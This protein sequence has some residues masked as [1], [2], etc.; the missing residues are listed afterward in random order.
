M[1]RITADSEDSL[2]IPADYVAV[3]MAAGGSSRFHADRHKLLTPIRGKPI[4]LHTIESVQ[5][6]GYG[7]IVVVI[8]AQAEAF[9]EILEKIPVMTVL[10][11]EWQQG[12]STSLQAGIRNLPDM[13]RSACLVLADQPFVS[14]RTY[15]E[16]AQSQQEHANRIIVP[17]FKGKYGNPTMFPA[18]T[19]AELKTQPAEDSGGRR[20]LRKYGAVEVETDDPFVIRDID[21]L[22]D[23]RKYS[24]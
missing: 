2:P 19:F 1:A 15:H 13:I 5:S 16:L 21:T 23:F 17:T 24:E 7:T 20:L 4:I 14:Q 18:I 11:P 12:Q 3:I 22:E 6:A 8:G 9:S 10:N